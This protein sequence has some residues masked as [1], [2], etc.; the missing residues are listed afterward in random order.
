MQFMLLIYENEA[1]WDALSE[2]ERRAST[3]RHIAFAR[4]LR[5]DGL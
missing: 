2:E 4:A 3:G 5:D 1:D